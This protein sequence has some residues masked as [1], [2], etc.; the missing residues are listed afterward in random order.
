MAIDLR[1]ADYLPYMHTE[2]N[3]PSTTVTEILFPK[4]VNQVTI[5]CETHKLLVYQS[6]PTDGA[7]KSTSWGHMFI[8]AGNVLAIKVGRGGT[9][10]PA[11]YVVADSSTP[12]INIMIEEY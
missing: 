3:L 6:G 10:A 4:E 1:S 2:T 9:R 8:P 5:G 11:L 12:T 7:I